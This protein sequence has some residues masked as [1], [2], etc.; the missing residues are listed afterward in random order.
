[1][2][3]MEAVKILQCH[4]SEI[5]DVCVTS[6]GQHFVTAGSDSTVKVFLLSSGRCLRDLKSSSPI[7]CVD[8]GRSQGGRGCQGTSDS[9]S[10]G[11]QWVVAG[12]A[13]GSCRVWSLQTGML[14][15]QFTGHASKV[16]ACNILG[17]LIV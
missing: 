15:L 7:I 12:G 4:N 16:Q 5:N 3:S 11:D 2:I 13:D 14:Q 1:M 10:G 9:S 17:N 6:T 8:V